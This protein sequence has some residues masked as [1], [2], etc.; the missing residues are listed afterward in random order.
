MFFVFQKVMIWI[1]KKNTS[2]I[3]TLIVQR[4]FKK[5]MIIIQILVEVWVK[6]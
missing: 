5:E 1:S 3:L 4:I 6:K 2:N